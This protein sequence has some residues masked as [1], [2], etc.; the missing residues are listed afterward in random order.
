[1][2]KIYYDELGFRLR[3]EGHAGAGSKGEDI[4]CAGLSALSF[5]LIKAAEQTEDFRA[6]VTVDELQGLVEVKC[7]PRGAWG[8]TKCG[9]VMDTIAGGFALM[10]EKYPEYVKFEKKEVPDE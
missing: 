2:T 4:V 6:A 3:I 5:T 10:A 8:V 9:I 7:K 1:M